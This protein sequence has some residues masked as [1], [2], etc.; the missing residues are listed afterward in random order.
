MILLQTYP[1]TT[2]YIQALCAIATVILAI[3]TIL[4]GNKI[5]ELADIVE[6]LKR[7][8]ETLTK[9]FNIE[10]IANMRQ[11]IPIFQ[12]DQIDENNEINYVDIFLRNI[13]VSFQFININNSSDNILE[14]QNINTEGNS[15]RPP[16]IRVL[17]K[18]GEKRDNYEFDVVIKSGTG[19]Q[20]T[21]RFIKKEGFRADISPPE[22]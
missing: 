2:D 12:I 19:H 11:S 5:K 17:F 7:S 20:H 6:E 16:R 22:Y 21:Q 3:A 10:K 14:F 1:S 4:Q 15:N 8:N 13:G 18:K 9:R